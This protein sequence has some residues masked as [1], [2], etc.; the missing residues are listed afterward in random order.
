MKIKTRK[1]IAAITATALLGSALGV[2]T[3]AITKS[4]NDFGFKGT[5]DLNAFAATADPQTKTV[6]GKDI[7]TT[8]ALCLTSDTDN[9]GVANYT[10]FVSIIDTDDT[11]ALSY[12][13]VGYSIGGKYYNGTTEGLSNVVYSSLTV[14]STEGGTATVTAA[15]LATNYTKITSPMLIITEVVGE[16]ESA[17]IE[18]NGFA[19]VSTTFSG[20]K[21]VNTFFTVSG[22]GEKTGLSLN[23]KGDTLTSGFKLNSNGVVNFSAPLTTATT[24]TLGMPGSYASTK[25]KTIGVY[26]V[27]GSQETLVDSK[28]IDEK[29][30]LTFDLPA[31]A[32]GETYRIHRV[33]SSESFLYY[34]DIVKQHTDHSYTLSKVT[35]VPSA[36][37]KGAVE[38]ICSL[39]GETKAVELPVTSDKSYTVGTPVTTNEGH[40]ISTP[41]TCTVEGVEVSFNVETKE[42]TYDATPVS[43]DGWKWSKDSEGNWGA[44][45]D[46]TYKCAVCQTQKV[47]DYTVTD[48]SS[49]EVTGDNPGVNYTGTITINENVYTNTWF[50][51]STAPTTAEDSIDISTDTDT[52]GHSMSFTSA[53]GY[54]TVAGVGNYKKA[55]VKNLGGDAM[56][57][58]SKGRGLKI[59]CASTGV[60]SVTIK[61]KVGLGTDSKYGT[62]SK[63]ATVAYAD[64][65]GVAISDG[66]I[67]SIGDGKTVVAEYTIIV[68]A[69]ETVTITADNQIALIGATAVVTLA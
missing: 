57:G 12:I 9:D 18:I 45:A 35:K 49:S 46:I 69:G 37:E 11:S 62:A 5:Y 14:N 36:T 32:D 19:P 7:D 43:V 4:N 58:T 38:L 28:T 56:I 3:Y 63:A 66:R 21:P 26:K 30:E 52:S 31:N 24:V 59:T 47:E 44:T 8:T 67:T 10:L 20:G 55:T 39:G 60:S 23:Y 41:Y 22:G 2:G 13:K 42:H 33:S 1:L 68:N 40:D 64:S 17:A 6:M 27:N 50:V 54:F 53:S 29:N 48:I 15:E 16:A 65:K 61:L 34:I 25:T 51:S